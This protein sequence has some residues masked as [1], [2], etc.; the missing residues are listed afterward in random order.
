META[1]HCNVEFETATFG[2]LPV[3]EKI[4]VLTAQELGNIGTH[5]FAPVARLRQSVV[6]GID[7]KEA[8]F[9]QAMFGSGKHLSSLIEI[10]VSYRTRDIDP[11][12]IVVFL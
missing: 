3:G 8:T 11:C 5:V 1:G 12:P 10:I 7:G 9:A 6:H 4:D 2:V